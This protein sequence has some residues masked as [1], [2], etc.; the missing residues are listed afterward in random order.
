[1]AKVGDFEFLR[2]SDYLI[3]KETLPS[4]VSDL[5]IF[6]RVQISFKDETYFNTD[7]VFD[8]LQGEYLPC[9][10]LA[11]TGSSMDPQL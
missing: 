11:I 2:A 8:L 9:G 3:T 4:V 6:K 10:T 7:R 5:N 1:M